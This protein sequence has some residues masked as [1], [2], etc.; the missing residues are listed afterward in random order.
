MILRIPADKAPTGYPYMYHIRHDEDNWIKPVELERFVLVNFFGTVFMKEPVEIDESG[1]VEIKRFWME[2]GKFI[3]F[4]IRDS[5]L[6]RT[7]GLP[8]DPTG[9]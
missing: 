4:R 3:K 5:I 9:R 6:R 8:D 7:F 1:Y 2:K